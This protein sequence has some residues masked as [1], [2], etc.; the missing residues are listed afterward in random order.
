M[1]RTEG[2]GQ[3]VVDKEDEGLL[4]AGMSNCDYVP[5]CIK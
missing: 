2:R 1:R 4:S 3:V 5:A